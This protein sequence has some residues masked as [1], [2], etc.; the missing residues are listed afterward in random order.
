[1]TDGSKPEALEGG[2][3]ESRRCSVEGKE[4]HPLT[5]NSAFLNR[6]SRLLKKAMVSIV[7]VTPAM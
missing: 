3:M 7:D 4:N 6:L 2:E 5:A 1:M